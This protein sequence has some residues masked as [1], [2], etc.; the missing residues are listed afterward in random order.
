MTEEQKSDQRIEK[1]RS[2]SANVYEIA[3]FMDWDEDEFNQLC[4]LV[5]PK[6]ANV[7]LQIFFEFR[8][9]IIHEREA[10]RNAEYSDLNTKFVQQSMANALLNN[11]HIKVMK[12]LTII[13]AIATAIQ[14]V[15]IALSFVFK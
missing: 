3:Q 13:L 14:A 11:K 8:G 12:N 4:K 9:T 7:E 15:F 10:K 6:I 5:I 2:N 1:L